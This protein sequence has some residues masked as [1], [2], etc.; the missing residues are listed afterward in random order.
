[1]FGVS[2]T[3]HDP[4]ENAE[5]AKRW[6]IR[7]GSSSK[8]LKGFPSHQDFTVYLGVDFQVSIHEKR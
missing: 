6:A 1:M 8:P 4:E 7:R 5:M 2:S 3:L